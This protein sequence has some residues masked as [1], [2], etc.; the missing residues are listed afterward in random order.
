MPFVKNGAGKLTDSVDGKKLSAKKSDKKLTKKSDK[1]PKPSA[2][3]ELL[4]KTPVKDC[5]DGEPA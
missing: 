1:A 3:K 2:V 4:K 5:S